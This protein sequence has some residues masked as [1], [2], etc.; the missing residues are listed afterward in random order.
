M[1]TVTVS[2]QVTPSTRLLDKYVLPKVALVVI[3]LASLIGTWLTMSTHNAYAWTQVVPRWLHLITFATLAGGSMWKAL[4]V[5]PGESLSH[6]EP[7]ARFASGEFRRFR[8]V[9]QIV[10]PIFLA[11]AVWDALRFSGWGAGWIAWADLALAAAIAAV[12]GAD[13][14][15]GARPDP[16]AERRLAR[17]ALAL[18]VLDA[19]AQAALDVV[20][21][22]GWSWLPLFAR[23]LHIGAFGLWFGG[24]LWNIFIAVPA[25]REIV[26]LPVVV[27]ASQQLERFRVAVRM[28]LPTLIVT[29]A[30]QAYR[31]VGLNPAALAASIVGYLILAK[32]ALLGALIAIFLTCPMWRACSPIAGMCKLDDLYQKGK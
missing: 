32:L 26:S 21:T 8:R 14:Y 31:Y 27:S 4:F 18:F 28:I 16:F 1:A 10:L 9:A 20:L 11:G 19:L 23:W 29:G 30:I 13:A 22:Q 6:H 7:F 5:Q 15:L 24:A 12:A 25:A 17:T 2:A 3:T